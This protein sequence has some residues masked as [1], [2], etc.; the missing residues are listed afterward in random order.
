MTLGV[1]GTMVWDRIDHPDGDTVERWGGIGYALAAAAAAAPEGWTLRPIVRLGADLA[2]QGRAFLESVPGLE[3]PGAVVVVD[4]PNN[5]VH[6][7]YR[8]RHDR[9]EHLTGGVGPWEWPDLAPHLEGLDGLY[10]NMIS[11]FELDHDTAAALRD[12]F[13]GPRYIDLHSLVLG[14][15]EDGRRVPRRPDHAPTWLGA[16][17]VVQANETELEVMAGGRPPEDVARTSFAHGARAMV[18]TRGPQ[19]ASWFA[20]GDRP[21][22]PVSEGSEG[23]EAGIPGAHSDPSAPDGPEIQAGEVPIGEAWT[24]GDPTGCGDVWGATCF[25]YLMRGRS[26]TDAMDQGNRAAARNVEHRGA[27]GLYQHL[28]GDA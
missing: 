11:G 18:V 4:E 5:R 14:V 12:R 20:R 9:D 16:F 15:D 28:R 17:H 26:L 22:W 25:A 7:R 1:L 21:V 8:D 19:G 2:D 6:L 27:D 13:S 24:A 10:V 3:L 23:S